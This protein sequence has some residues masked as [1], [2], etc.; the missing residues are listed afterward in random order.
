MTSQRALHWSVVIVSLLLCLGLVSTHPDP[1]APELVLKPLD[2]VTVEGQSLVMK[3]F[4]KNKKSRDTESSSGHVIKPTKVMTSDQLITFSYKP[5]ESSHP[6]IAFNKTVYRSNASH[7]H[8]HIANVSLIWDYTQI[9]CERPPSYRSN[10]ILRICKKILVPVIKD[11]VWNNWSQI[12]FHWLRDESRGLTDRCPVNYTVMYSRTNKGSKESSVFQPCPHILDNVCTLGI[13]QLDEYKYLYEVK[14]SA[15]NILQNVSTLRRLTNIS[16]HCKPSA[17]PNAS[18]MYNG[19]EGTVVFERPVVTINLTCN[20]TI[21]CLHSTSI[22]DVERTFQTGLQSFI[23]PS[24]NFTLHHCLPYYTNC[25]HDHVC[26][27]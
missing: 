6:I 1:K 9:L 11:I 4:M 25:S 20:L 5:R 24:Y 21:H 13:S 8:L 18:V 19:C 15:H 12:S 16:E 2:P 22:P 26:Q 23:D 17:V 14:V 27:V 7:A 3:C 10:Q